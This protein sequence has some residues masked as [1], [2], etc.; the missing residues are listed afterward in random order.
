MDFFNRLDGVEMINAWVKANLVHNCNPC[1]LALLLQL[2][3]GRRYVAS[4]DHVLLF[5]NRRLDDCGVKRVRNQRYNKVTSTDLSIEGRFV[6]D[7]ER[8]WAGVL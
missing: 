6:S 5:A 3:H 1:V 2:Q 4:G 8:D 7:I